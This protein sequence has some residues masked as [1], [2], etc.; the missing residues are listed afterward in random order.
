MQF[1]VFMVVF[2]VLRIVGKISRLSTMCPEI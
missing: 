2:E 1:P